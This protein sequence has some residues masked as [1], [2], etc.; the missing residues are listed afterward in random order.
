MCLEKKTKYSLWQPHAKLLLWEGDLILQQSHKWETFIFLLQKSLTSA[1]S[2]L[3]QYNGEM[4]M[5]CFRP[6]SFWYRLILPCL[7]WINWNHCFRKRN[8]VC[9]VL[10]E[11][12]IHHMQQWAR[13]IH[14]LTKVIELFSSHV[15]PVMSAGLM[16]S[17]FILAGFHL[18]P[19]GWLVLYLTA[20]MGKIRLVSHKKNTHCRSCVSLRVLLIRCV[21][22]ENCTCHSHAWEWHLKQS[23]QTELHAAKS[24]FF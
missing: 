16:A 4:T 13:S 18:H 9:N 14:L 10:A 6:L 5:C 1:P 23:V 15:Q 2:E 22:T 19:A 12:W 24:S 17:L 20:E 21:V 8:L 11:K 3:Y 7:C